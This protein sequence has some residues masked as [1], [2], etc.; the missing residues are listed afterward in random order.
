MSSSQKPQERS[1]VCATRELPAGANDQK[2]Q[3]LM[4]GLPVGQTDRKRLW[5]AT[6]SLCTQVSLNQVCL[7][8]GWPMYELGGL[9]S[10]F[11]VQWIDFL[12]CKERI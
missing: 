3:V 8:Q 1:E 6:S 11:R 5:R 10:T 12:L 9:G 2:A 4:S 7:I